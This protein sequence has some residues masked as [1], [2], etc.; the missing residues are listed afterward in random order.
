MDTL[1]TDLN[2]G[3]CLALIAAWAGTMGF[4]LMEYQLNQ[5]IW[6]ITAGI[7]ALGLVLVLSLARHFKNRTLL[8]HS[9]TYTVLAKLFGFLKEVYDSGSIAWKV[10]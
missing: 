7:G 2:L 3:L 9:L 1:Y 10:I 8:K 5:A 6:P 4:I